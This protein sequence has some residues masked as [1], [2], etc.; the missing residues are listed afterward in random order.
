[1][2]ALHSRAEV[3]DFVHDD[4]LLHADEQQRQPRRDEN[5][6]HEGRENRP[7]MCGAQTGMCASRQDL[8]LV[9]RLGKAVR[10]QRRQLERFVF[11]DLVL[12]DER[13]EKAAI[14]S[15]RN[16]MSRWDG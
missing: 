7:Q 11:V 15:A 1:M 8:Q 9:R 4:L 12:D 13:R 14:H 10:Q 3:I 2:S 16:V 5:A 6:D